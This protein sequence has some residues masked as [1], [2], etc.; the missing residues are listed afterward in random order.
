MNCGP[1]GDPTMIRHDSPLST[2]GGGG[3]SSLRDGLD[4]GSDGA[5]GSRDGAAASE[6]GSAVTRCP[7]AG[8][9]GNGG[10]IGGEGGGT[11]LSRRCGAMEEAA[12]VNAG[13]EE[14]ALVA[15]NGVTQGVTAR[16][17]PWSWYGGAWL[18]VLPP[19][20]PAFAS[21]SRDWTPAQPKSRASSVMPSCTPPLTRMPSRPVGRM[22]CEAVHGSP[23]LPCMGM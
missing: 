1:L 18:V 21:A 12:G 19:R 7:A 2:M 20:S 5:E 8:G 13:A 3:R 4:K 16:S 11:P 6:G 23:R 9:G 14:P 15:L 22:L 17:D 10:G